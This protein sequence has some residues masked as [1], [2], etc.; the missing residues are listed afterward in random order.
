MFVAQFTCT[1]S[2]DGAVNPGRN[3]CQVCYGQVT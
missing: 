1:C 2:V 3:V